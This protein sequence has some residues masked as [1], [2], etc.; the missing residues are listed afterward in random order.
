VP[1][2]IVRGA[3]AGAG[4]VRL[5]AAGHRRRRVSKCGQWA[6]RQ[7]EDDREQAAGDSETSEATLHKIIV[8]ARAGG[9]KMRVG[10][11]SLYRDSSSCG[12]V[13]AHAVTLRIWSRRHEGRY[14]GFI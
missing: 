14:Q 7:R 5:G 1:A 12:G 9:I 4:V 8:R 10:I 13:P 2:A 11:G 3:Q 6:S